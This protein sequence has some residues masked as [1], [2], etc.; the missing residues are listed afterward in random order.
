MTV[1]FN[2]IFNFKPIPNWAFWIYLVKPNTG[3]YSETTAVSSHP[4]YVGEFKVC[5][6]EQL[7]EQPLQQCFTINGF[8]VW[9]LLVCHW[10][11][12]FLVRGL[13]WDFGSSVITVW[14]SILILATEDISALNIAFVYLYADLYI[15]KI[16]HII[17]W[18]WM[19]CSC[20]SSLLW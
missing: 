2:L 10:K 11:E 12:T 18:W 19:F 20:R 1:T 14:Y 5:R 4:I 9:Q 16:Y 8:T 6:V 3:F 13:R 17:A 7:K 15:E